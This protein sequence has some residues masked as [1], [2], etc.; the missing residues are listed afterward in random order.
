M[1]VSA[2]HIMR[3]A[4]LGA[5]A[6]L[7][8]CATSSKDPVFVTMSTDPR[9]ATVSFGDGTSCTTPCQIGVKTTLEALVARAGYAPKTVYLDRKSSRKVHVTLLPVGRSEAVEEI[10]LPDL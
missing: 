7:A 10:Q 8:S 4:V 5:A 6:S 9:G 2:R 3:V 1:N